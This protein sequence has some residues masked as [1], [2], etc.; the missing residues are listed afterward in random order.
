MPFVA[1]S[2]PVDPKKFMLGGVK[3]NTTSRF[4]TREMAQSAL[5]STIEIHAQ[6]TPPTKVQGEVKEVEGSIEVFS[7]GSTPGCGWGRA[8]DIKRIK[9]EEREAQRRK[10]AEEEAAFKNSLGKEYG[11]T[12]NPKFNRCYEIA[13]YMGHSSGYNEVA[14]YFGELVELIK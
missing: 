7:D 5:N 2:K 3:E 1:Y 11:V 13:W 6:L 14:M 9:H 10:T 4:E 8:L 12:D